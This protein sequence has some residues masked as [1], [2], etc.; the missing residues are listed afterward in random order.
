VVDRL[1]GLG[2]RAGMIDEGTV[3]F[4]LHKDVDDDDLTRVVRVLDE[5]AGA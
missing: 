2:V 1:A 4:V 5:L 3:R